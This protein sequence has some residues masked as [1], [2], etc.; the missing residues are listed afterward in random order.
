MGGGKESVGEAIEAP[1]GDAAA[2]DDDKAGQVIALLAESVRGP[3]P[4]AGPPLQAGPAMKKVVCRGV[5]GELGRHRTHDAEVVGVLRDMWEKIAH[6]GTALPALFE[7][8]RR[9]EDLADIVELRLLELSDRL[10]GILA[11]VFLQ[12]R[13]VVEGVDLG[14]PAFHEEEDDIA[15]LGGEVT[16]RDQGRGGLG[17]VHE[18]CHGEAAEAQGGPLEDFAASGKRA[19]HHR[20]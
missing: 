8:P 15:R 1:G 20:K 2:V 12:S 5:L 16:V 10:A 6:P 7:G 19:L 4:H 9:F 18:S 11:V 14:D 3:R 17:L 13:L